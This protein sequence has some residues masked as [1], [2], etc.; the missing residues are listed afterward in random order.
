LNPSLVAEGEE[1]SGGRVVS[2]ARA[3]QGGPSVALGGFRREKP[4]APAARVGGEGAETVFGIAF[5]HPLTKTADRAG[6]RP[7]KGR[8]RS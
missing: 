6:K 4:S 8:T 3:P 5:A 2:S 1:T 7:P